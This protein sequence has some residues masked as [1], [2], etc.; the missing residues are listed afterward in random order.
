MSRVTTESTQ[1]DDRLQLELMDDLLGCSDDELD[2]VSSHP[3]YESAGCAELEMAEA[4]SSPLLIK[5]TFWHIDEPAIPVR[6]VR[7]DGDFV[8]LRPVSA[9]SQQNVRSEKSG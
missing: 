9:C 6:R 3:L 7:S 5:N 4:S 8:C 2:D 1:C